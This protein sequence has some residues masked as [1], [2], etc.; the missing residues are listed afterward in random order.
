MLN[1]TGA[2]DVVVSDVR[3]TILEI[4]GENSPEYR[5]HQFLQ[6]W[7]GPMFVNMGQQAILEGTERGRQKVFCI[8]KGLEKRLQEKSEDFACENRFNCERDHSRP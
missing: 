7:A 2:D 4:F 8:L 1:K 3:V 6:M 5:Q